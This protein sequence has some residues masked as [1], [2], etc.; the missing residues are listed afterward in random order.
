MKIQSLNG[1]VD[2]ISLKSEKT[3][4]IKIGDKWYQ[5]FKKEYQSENNSIGFQQISDGDIKKGTPVYLTYKQNVFNN[6]IT[7]NIVEL[8]AQS[9]E[10]KA[11]HETQETKTS[12]QPTNQV[13]WDRLGKIKAFHNL[14]GSMLASGVDIAEVV[15]TIRSGA[16]NEVCVEIENAVDG[17][18]QPTIDYDE[19]SLSDVQF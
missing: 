16:F 4:S 9:G 7:N 10:A 3:Y 11:V 8:T 1:I 14:A 5:G 2:A 13:N 18:K 19:E 15:K 6:N 17:I 12:T